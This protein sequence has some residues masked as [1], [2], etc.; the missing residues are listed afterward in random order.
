MLAGTPCYCLTHVRRFL[1]VFFRGAGTN[2]ELA[3]TNKF[4]LGNLSIEER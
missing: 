4:M 1:V 3:F 2:V